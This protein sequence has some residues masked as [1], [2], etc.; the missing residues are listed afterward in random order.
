MYLSQYE[1]QPHNDISLKE[2][3]KLREN[4]ELM[5]VVSN[6]K[7]HNPALSSKDI[8]QMAA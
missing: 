3:K 5:K 6:A 2:L 4:K 8:R 1:F 7:K